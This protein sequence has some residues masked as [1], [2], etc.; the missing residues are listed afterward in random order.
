MIRQTP[1]CELFTAGNNAIDGESGPCVNVVIG[2][3]EPGEACAEHRHCNG[4]AEC[5][6][7]DDTCGGTRVA[8]VGEGEDCSEAPCQ[9]GLRCDAGTCP[10]KS[11]EGEPCS[12]D[13]ACAGDLIC[14]DD[15]TC[16]QLPELAGDSCSDSVNNSQCPGTLPCVGG[17][18]QEGAA[19]VEACGGTADC[20]P[21]NRCVEGTCTEVVGPGENCDSTASCVISH[22]CKDG[23][24]QPRP[25]VGGD[26]SDEPDFYANDSNSNFCF[27]GACQ[28]GTCEF[29]SKGKTCTASANLVGDVCEESVRTANRQGGAG[30]TLQAR[31]ES[32][33]SAAECE[34]DLECRE[35]ASGSEIGLPAC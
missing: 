26:C 13:E 2:T 25:V 29:R 35:D 27:T 11:E 5:N 24:C 12:E 18:C 23:T 31:G 6:L 14:D 7:G 16:S 8:A 15:G 3:Q 21:G 19:S 28:S 30:C 20:A 9:Q 1:A 4:R 17:T 10:S 34:E 22:Y 32:C 33:E